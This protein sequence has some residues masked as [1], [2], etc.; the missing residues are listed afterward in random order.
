MAKAPGSLH[1]L[2]QVLDPVLALAVLFLAIVLRQ[3]GGG[4]EVAGQGLQVQVTGT[5]AMGVDQAQELIDG[6]RGA[7]GEGAAAGQIAGRPPKRDPRLPRLLAQAI[8]GA[9]A[10]APGRIVDGSLEGGVVVRVG[11]QA[12]VGHGVLDLGA[13][14]EA[15]AA[16]DPVG[17]LGLEQGLLEQP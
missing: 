10:D 1:Q 4:D 12:Q 2:L 16:I 7:G 6:S 11:D 14:E 9:Q 17:D 8:Q 13:L 3:A 15:Q 5:G